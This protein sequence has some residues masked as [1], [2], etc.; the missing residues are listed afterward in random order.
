MKTFNDIPV[1]GRFVCNGNL[2][3]KKSSRTAFID[4]KAKILWFYFGLTESVTPGWPVETA[5]A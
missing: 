3:T 5:A 4:G 2:C 1:G